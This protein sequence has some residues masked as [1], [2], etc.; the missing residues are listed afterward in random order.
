MGC[1]FLDSCFFADKHISICV[2]GL[3][4]F[5]EFLNT[6]GTQVGIVQI[7]IGLQMLLNFFEL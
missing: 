7:Y 4:I 6:L 5:L 2:D 1:H 3:H